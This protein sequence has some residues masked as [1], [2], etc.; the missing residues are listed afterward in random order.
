MPSLINNLIQKSLHMAY[1][2]NL[3]IFYLGGPLMKAEQLLK[4]GK[5]GERV[6]GLYM[7]THLIFLDILK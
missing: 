6:K 1:L 7:Q 2:G 5:R 4:N 3:R